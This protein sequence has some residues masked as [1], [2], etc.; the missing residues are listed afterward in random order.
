MTLEDILEE[1]VGEIVDETDLPEEPLIRISKNEIIADGALDLREINYAFNL[2]LPQLE[3]RSLNG[4][5]HRGVGLRSGARGKLRAPGGP[6]RRRGRHGDPGGEGPGPEAHLGRPQKGRL[7]LAV[8]LPFAGELPEIAPD[9]FLAPTAVIIGRVNVG[10]KASIWFGAVLRGDHPVHG[11]EVGPRS[12]VQ[13]N[14]VVH[15]GDWQP[16]VIGADVTVGHGAKFES[17]TI[18]DGCVIGMNAV[19]LQEARIG[20]GSLVAANSV[21]LEKAEIPPGSLVAGVPGKVRRVLDGSAARFVRRS[22]SHYVELSTTY[23]AEGIQEEDRC[24]ECGGH[25]FLGQRETICLNCRSR[26]PAASP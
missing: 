21:V 15:V 4:Y 20:A 10:A 8:I 14:A 9:A 23:G 11:I 5:H 17:C 3:H 6:H 26:R 16:T 22:S 24:D 19:I 7:S 2:S 1:L 25:L 12:N 13:D 18:E